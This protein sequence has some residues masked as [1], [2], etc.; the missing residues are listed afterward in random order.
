MKLDYFDLISPSP[1]EIV[2]I[3]SIISPTLK[4]IQNI[5]YY[6]Y[7]LY[8]SSLEMSPEKYFENLEKD[9][10][11]VIDAEQILK[12][13]KYDLLLNDISLRNT[14][15]KAL[16][17]FLV[18]DVV[19]D[20]DTGVFITIQKDTNGL[21]G[22]ISGFIGRQNYKAVVDI[23]LQRLHIDIDEDEVEDLSKVTNMRGKKIYEKILNGRKRMR[24]AKQKKGN[25]CYTLPN[26]ISSVAAYSKNTNYIQIWDLTVY[27][28]LDLFDRLKLVDQYE[29]I[30]TKVSV[31]GDE[32][33]QFKFGLWNKNLYEKDKES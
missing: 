7:G 33:N 1:F 15:E 24:K 5:S 10:K 4:D 13:T 22:T 6:T 26:I 29:M 18:E 25:S 27:Q 31:W 3:G 21:S 14:I 8:V 12:T 23:I 28:L 9:H 32:N 2:N 17:F 20:E 19:Y 30:H 11:I 16:N